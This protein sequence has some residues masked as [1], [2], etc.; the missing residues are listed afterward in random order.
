MIRFYNEDCEKTMQRMKL[1]GAKVDTILTS[2]PYNT[3]RKSNSE[4]SRKENEARYDIHLDNIP[5][6]KY[7]DWCVKLFNDFDELLNKNG[8]VLWNMSYGADNTGNAESI[9]LMWH[10]ISEIIKQTDFMVADRIIW[11][12]ANALPNNT[13]PNK[14]TRIVEDVFVFCR[15]KEYKTFNCRKPVTSTNSR[16]Q[17]YYQPIY[18]FIEARNNDGSC[19]Y[20]KATF[21]SELCEK[22]LTIYGVERGTVYDPFM[23]SGTTA[24]ACERLCMD[25]IGSELSENQVNYSYD[26]I[27]KEFGNN[28][29]VFKEVV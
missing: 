2:P 23:G 14:L 12:K 27:V 22:L 3:G 15:K 25:C 10:T 19:P 21:S 4:R 28:C 7:I 6:E 11:K 17:K 13:S 24:V 26:R 20:N 1:M 18:N 5:T 29:T 16:G 9:C 8:V